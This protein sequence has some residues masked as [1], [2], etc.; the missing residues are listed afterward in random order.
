MTP[1]VAAHSATYCNGK[2][3]LLQGSVQE[4]GLGCRDGKEDGSV[5]KMGCRLAFQQEDS[6]GICWIFHLE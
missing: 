1:T 3:K 6:E 2:G 5:W 4:M